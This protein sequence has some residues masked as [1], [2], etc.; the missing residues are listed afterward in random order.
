MMEGLGYDIFMPDYRGYGKSEGEQVSGEQF[1]QDTQVVYDFLL[2]HYDEN[3]IVVVGY[4]LGSG[5][6]SYITGVNKPKELFL[7]SPFKSIVDMKDRYIPIVPDFLVNFQFPNW[8]YLEQT[9]CPITI[10][11]SPID[12]IVLPG[13]TLALTEY[14]DHEELVRL[15]GTSHRGM[16][17]HREWRKVLQNNLLR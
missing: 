2:D 13:S 3:E 8:K 5:P 11:Y 12:S 9:T 10:F 1:Y 14:S 7:L 6:A 15:D 4:S 16:I 17:F